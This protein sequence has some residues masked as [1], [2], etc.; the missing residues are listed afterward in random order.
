MKKVDRRLEE[1]VSADQVFFIHILALIDLR[2]KLFLRRQF[3]VESVDQLEHVISFSC[4][5]STQDFDEVLSNAKSEVD[6]ARLELQ[7]KEANKFTYQE[8][9]DRIQKMQTSSR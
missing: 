3:I 5:S 1:V 7:V 4:P 8:F 9:I 6:K 2:I